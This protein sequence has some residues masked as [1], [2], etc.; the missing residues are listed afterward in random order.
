[1]HKFVSAEIA[2][3]SLLCLR[4]VHVMVMVIWFYNIELHQAF[5][6]FRALYIQILDTCRCYI[7]AKHDMYSCFNSKLSWYHVFVEYGSNG[8]HVLDI[9]GSIGCDTFTEKEPCAGSTCFRIGISII[10][11][12]KM[13]I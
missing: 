7:M 6:P 13:P 11:Y 10:S 9:C 8:L 12:I 1:M 3:C 5:G 2:D 4:T